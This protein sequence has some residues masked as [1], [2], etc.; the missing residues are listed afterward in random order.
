MVCVISLYHRSGRVCVCVCMTTRV[1]R[2]FLEKS[3]SILHSAIYMYKTLQPT[4]S[5]I[6]RSSIYQLD[7]PAVT[8]IP[9]SPSISFSYSTST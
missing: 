9:P 6:R 3:T 5:N 4:T 7:A 1:E 8:A 2:F